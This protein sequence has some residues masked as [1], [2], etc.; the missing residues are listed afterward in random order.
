M[1]KHAI[2]VISVLALSLGLV[3]GP[4]G[5]KTFLQVKGSDTE[6][7]VVQRLAENYM[8]KDANTSIAVT[9]GGSGVGIAAIINKTTDLANSSRPMKDSEIAKAKA[10][11]VNPVG[12]AFAVDGLSVI[13]NPKNTLKSLTMDQIGQIFRGEA[14]NWKQMGGPDGPI[15][16][17][18]RQPNSGTFVFFREAVIKGDYSNKMNQ[19]NGNAQILEAVKKDAGGIGYVGIGYVLDD[20]GKVVPGINVLEVAKDSRSKPTSP[21]QLENIM[22]G[23][24]PI[25]RPLYQYFDKNNQAK[26]EGFIKYELGPEGT[27]IV[28][29][30]GFYPLTDQ[31]KKHNAPFG[32]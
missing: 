26:V 14:T 10:N 2:I 29:K 28:K 11:G 7:N 32:F 12:I 3:S 16:L 21:L 31:W 8:K 18:G 23:A 15:T 20:A 22:S 13:V 30:D 4:V 6:V 1:R 19:M 27:A 25:T 9:G 17:Y 24:Y 5:A